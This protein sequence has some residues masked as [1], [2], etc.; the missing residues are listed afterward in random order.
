MKKSEFTSRR[1][2]LSYN[3]ATELV[4]LFMKHL[5]LCEVKPGERIL[6]ITDPRFNPHYPAAFFGAGMALGAEVFQLTL[7]FT[8]KELPPY[9]GEIMKQANLVIGMTKVQWLYTRPH[10]EALESG[11]RTLMVVEAEDELIRLFP[12]REVQRRGL[13]GVKVLSAGRKIRI[14][15]DAGTDLLVD[16]GSRPVHC[17]YGF[18]DRPGRWDHWPQ[19]NVSVMP[20]EDQAEGVLV[21]DKGDVIYTPGIDRH[22]SEPIKLTYREGKIVEIEGGT[23]AMALK[24]WFESFHDER[25]YWISH[26]GWGIEE[27]AQWSIIGMDS[28]CFYGGIMVAYGRNIFPGSGGVNDTVAHGQVILR[29]CNFTVDGQVIVEKGRIVPENLR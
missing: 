25:A 19:G 22:V 24:E 8:T 9:A 1:W 12:R 17:S 14:T 21:V 18:S 27:R 23:D 29:N 6:L 15:S 13:E 10:A 16:K 4:P 7:P 2:P 5:Q 11:T 3:F 28:E 26:V 20:P